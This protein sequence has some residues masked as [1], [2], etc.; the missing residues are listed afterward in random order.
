M[1]ATV[2]VRPAF[3]IV[4]N[5][6]INVCRTALKCSCCCFRPSKRESAYEVSNRAS[7]TA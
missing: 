2:R 3:R 4:A 1:N 5:T 7:T 6:P